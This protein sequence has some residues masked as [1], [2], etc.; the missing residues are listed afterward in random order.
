MSPRKM[1]LLSTVLA[2]LTCVFWVIVEWHRLRL[3]LPFEDAAMLFR[4]AENLAGGAG[5]SWNPNEDPSLTDG[6][7][8]LGFVLLLA[9]LI[10]IGLPVAAAA[11]LINLVAIALTGF[12]LGIANLRLWR[13]SPW[14]A[15]AV[16]LVVM[17]GPVNRYVLSGFSAPVLAL[18]VLTSLVLAGLSGLAAESQQRTMLLVAAGTCAGLAGWWR[19][20]G[21]AFGP[22]AVLAGLILTRQPSAREANR[23]D[24]AATVIP[25]ALLFTGWIALRLLYFGQIVPT[26]GLMKG[27]FAPFNALASFEQY[28]ALLLP[29]VGLVVMAVTTPRSRG[30]SLLIAS[31]LACSLVWIN[32]AIPGWWWG[33]VGLPIIPS[34][35]DL[36][37]KL[38]VLPM[39]VA[40]LWVSLRERNRY[41]LFP[42][43]V[44]AASISWVFIETTLNWWGRM[45]WPLVPSLGALAACV[46]ARTTTPLGVPSREAWPRPRGRQLLAIGVLAALAILPSHLPRGGFTETPFHSTVYRALQE[47]DT[48]GVRLA[49][50]E[51]GLIPLAITGTA[52]DTWGHNN[53]SIAKSHGVSLEAELASFAPNMIVIHGPPPSETEPGKCGPEAGTAPVSPFDPEWT[54]MVTKLE[55]YALSNR[56]ELLRSN[57]TAPC[58][59][60]SVFVAPDLDLQVTQ[61]LNSYQMSG[62]DLKQAD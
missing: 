35:S 16:I 31:L 27:G 10:A 60:W 21:F 17:S 55:S 23:S 7:T 13:G 45:Q 46:I 47:V 26:S 28:V 59:A 41:W 43:A 9:P 34:L 33:R 19:P 2:P 42:S 36:G 22:M 20:E 40:I 25:I 58:D 8:D 32:A 54:A 11:I 5:L 3:P 39:L 57:E 30:G 52:L 14:L 44:F 4:Y 1:L 18:L 48:S 15:P 53:R 6:A 51:A 38:I 29:L 12:V 37:T 49:T 50:T 61:A 62:L 56:F 24:F